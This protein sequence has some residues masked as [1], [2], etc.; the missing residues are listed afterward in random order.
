MQRFIDRLKLQS[1]LRRATILHGSIRLAGHAIGAA[2]TFLLDRVNALLCALAAGML[3]FAL[4]AN[5]A[6]HAGRNLT[7]YD[8]DE[9]KC[10]ETL[11]HLLDRNM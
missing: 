3:R 9:K 8:E 4:T 1:G 2:T 5:T 7:G 6:A 11:H 10:S